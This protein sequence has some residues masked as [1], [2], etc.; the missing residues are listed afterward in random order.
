MVTQKAMGLDFWL[1]PLFLNSTCHLCI[2]DRPSCLRVPVDK[3]P[4]FMNKEHR[5]CVSSDLGPVLS[6]V[7]TFQS[8][9]LN[10]FLSQILLYLCLDKKDPLSHRG[11]WGDWLMEKPFSKSHGQR[12][13][14][15]Y[16]PW[17]GKR[18]RLDLAT[19]QGHSKGAMVP[20]L[21]AACTDRV[22]DERA[23]N[24]VPSP[25]SFNKSSSI[26]ICFI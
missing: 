14:A 22:G 23:L 10:N 5:L 12:S 19:E 16:S 26:F 9:P 18:V 25:P 1:C 8:S 7:C 6:L 17:G 13:L 24:S 15:G 3:Q 2:Y 4:R 21:L 11:S 20:P